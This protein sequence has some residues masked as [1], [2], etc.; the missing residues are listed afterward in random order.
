MNKCPNPYYKG[1]ECPYA[2]YRNVGLPCY[3]SQKSC[4]DWRK[5]LAK[6]ESMKQIEILRN[7]KEVKNAIEQLEVI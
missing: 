2:F 4:N 1:I 3:A 6:E 5:K 7:K